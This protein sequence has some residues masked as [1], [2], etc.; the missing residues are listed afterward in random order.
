M[1]DS[2]V[3]S[4]SGGYEFTL[5]Q[6]WFSGNV[7]SW[8]A[9]FSRV[10]ARA[11]R[12]LEIGTWEGRSSVF[13]LQELCKDTGELVTIDHY[14]LLQTEEGR[15]RR[16]RVGHNLGIAGGASRVIEAFSVPGLMSVLGEETTSAAP[17]FDWIYVDGSHRADDTLLDGELVWR[18]AR[19]G[20]II[21]FDDYCWP[22]ESDGS[23]LHPR[24]GIDA[25]LQLHAEE[26]E[27]L[28]QP[29]EYQMVIQKHVDMRIGWAHKDAGGA[30]VQTALDYGVN[31]GLAVNSDYA[32]PA[33]VAIH[34][35]V[36]ALTT[37]CT[38]Y[39]MDCGLSGEDR[40]KIVALPAPASER[41]SFVF[42]QPSEDDLCCAYGATWAKID[43]VR[44]IPAE[45]VLYL[46][47][48]VLVMG[49][50]VPL[51]T[52]DLKG[53]AL[54]A[55]ADVGHPKGHASLD[56]QVSRYFNAGVLLMDLAKMRGSIDDLLRLARSSLSSSYK[57]QDCLNAH[58]ADDWTELSLKYNAQ[59]VGTYAD[60]ITEERSILDL[61]SMSDPVIVHF[62]GPVHPPL[63]AVLNPWVQ[64]YTAKPWGY[65]GA[66]G[67]KFAAVWWESLEKTEWRGIR[68]TAAYKG[69]QRSE[70]EK[71]VE[72]A[73][74][75]FLE[76][77][78]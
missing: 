59:G 45:R 32:M 2:T 64:P 54:G 11:P 26:Y 19:A 12:A 27:R 60:I 47:A 44:R 72:D 57:D 6:D 14:D 24:R 9:L 30:A 18:L 67:H 69:R 33:T 34:S 40:E 16:A 63:V 65:A 66:P 62:T 75:Q 41:V 49:D 35:A 56:E 42:L 10:T 13:L 73:R 36:Q 22:A 4:D 48:D 70:K 55:A 50:L 74:S 43:M 76:L 58:F 37:R 20:A 7:A 39:V 46:D 53:K 8:R 23:M 71:A 17:G 29:G 51:W 15:K 3:A 28:S 1:N 21:I 5:T 77:L 78:K 38:V 31:L 61:A 68:D 25:F 52:T